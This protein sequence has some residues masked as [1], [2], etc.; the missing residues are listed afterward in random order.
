MLE[1]EE[2]LGRSTPFIGGDAR[3]DFSTPTDREASEMVRFLV[4]CTFIESLEFVAVAV[5]VVVIESR[6]VD[7]GIVVTEK[8]EG[9]EEDEAVVQDADKLLSDGEPR[10][11]FGERERR[12]LS[13][14][15]RRLRV[16]SSS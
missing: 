13:S 11:A 12:L 10:S 6:V 1:D 2:E 7:V 15:C 3:D 4:V 14:N 8:A 9:D 16:S 5:V